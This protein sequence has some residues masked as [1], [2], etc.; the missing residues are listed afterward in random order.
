MNPLLTKYYLNPQST[1]RASIPAEPAFNNVDYLTLRPVAGANLGPSTQIKFFLPTRN[2]SM[3][4]GEA[5]LCIEGSVKLSTLPYTRRKPDNT[6]ETITPADVVHLRSNFTAHLFS[7]ITLKL[8]DQVVEIEREPGLSSTVKLQVRSSDSE[9]PHLELAGISL[10]SPLAPPTIQQLNTEKTAISF[11]VIYP[12]RY[13]L[14]SLQDMVQV[15]KG[16]NL[17]LICQR[18]E[19]SSRCLKITDSFQPELNVLTLGK[20]ELVIPYV[21]LTDQGVLKQLEFFQS[22]ANQDISYRQHRIFINDDLPKGSTKLF[23]D[24]G[25]RSSTETPTHA[26]LAFFPNLKSYTLDQF[27]PINPRI[28]RVTAHVN[29]QRTHLSS[30][31]TDQDSS[32]SNHLMFYVNFLQFRLE[33]FGLTNLF[34]DTVGLYSKEQFKKSPYFCF[35]LHTDQNATFNSLDE[36]AFE[37]SFLENVPDDTIAVCIL[38]HQQLLSFNPKSQLVQTDRPIAGGA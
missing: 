16:C 28:Q 24:L 36:L 17:E 21:Q 26:I 11:S 6:T 32:T 29:G 10:G 30:L 2:L 25:P 14:D 12:L 4:L 18:S 7:Q 27:F 15:I 38:I 22:G 33:W 3:V 8:A 5:M 35:S 37:V 1:A 13:L 9:R 23:W 31:D 20:C 34:E 19:L